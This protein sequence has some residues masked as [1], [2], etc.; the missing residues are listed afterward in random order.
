MK[1]LLCGIMVTAFIFSAGAV[2]VFAGN[3]AFDQKC[4]NPNS[5]GV[6]D[7]ICT[8]NS[9]NFV[10]NNND[11][12]CDNL[13]AKSAPNYTDDNKDGICDNKGTNNCIRPQNGTG[14]QHGKNH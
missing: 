2:G 10:D 4:S 7:N 12:V 5:D 3:K 13:S 11:G 6:C 1:K 14:K 9:S 8:I